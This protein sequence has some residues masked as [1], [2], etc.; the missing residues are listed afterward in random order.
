MDQSIKICKIFHFFNHLHKQISSITFV[1]YAV[2]LKNP[3]IFLHPI[4]QSLSVDAKVSRILSL[5]I[6]P[7]TNLV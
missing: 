3:L 1:H 7:D 2:V 6:I 4:M 5:K